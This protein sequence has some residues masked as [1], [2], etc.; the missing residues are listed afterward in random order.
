MKLEVLYW[1]QTKKWDENNTNSKKL[2]V[3]EEIREI[4]IY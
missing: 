3:K 1:D 2:Q 4:K